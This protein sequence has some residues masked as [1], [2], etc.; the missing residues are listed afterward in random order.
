MN[1]PHVTTRMVVKN[2]SPHVTAKTLTDFFAPHGDVRAVS[3]ATDIMTGSCQGVGF[4]S[5]DEPHTGAAQLALDGSKL[6]GRLV[7]VAIER[8]AVRQ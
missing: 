8:K 1:K 7:S 5:L 3:L 6:G 2:L 4:V